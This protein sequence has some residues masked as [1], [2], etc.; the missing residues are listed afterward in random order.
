MCEPEDRSQAPS[1]DTLLEWLEEEDGAEA[2]DGCWVE[3][4]GVCE[5]GCRSWLLVMGLI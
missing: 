2:T 3:L 5:H 4:D 1:M